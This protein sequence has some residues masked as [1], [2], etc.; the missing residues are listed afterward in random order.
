[1]KWIIAVIGVVI[2]VCCAIFIMRVQTASLSPKATTT[3]SAPDTP[4]AKPTPPPP[5][6]WI[7]PPVREPFKFNSYLP[8]GSRPSTVAMPGTTTV[9]H[10]EYADDYQSRN[11][12][13]VLRVGTQGMSYDPKL[14]GPA[15]SGP[16]DVLV[17][18][19]EHYV[20]FRT[21]QIS[22]AYH[23]ESVVNIIDIPH[24]RTFAVQPPHTVGDY[25]VN[26]NQY[27]DLLTF[28]SYAWNANDTLNVTFYYVGLAAREND[29][30]PEQYYRISHKELWQYDVAAKKYTFL[31]TLP[32]SQ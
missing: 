23:Q 19:D 9:I 15:G 11:P 30:E 20:A 4:V 29:S 17:S 5:Q 10:F 14:W 18:S 13:L 2:A 6:K 31:Q 28:Y 3:A 21:L 8:S 12:G 32:E 1:M 27:K 24:A 26:P 16:F 22:G 25:N 7:T